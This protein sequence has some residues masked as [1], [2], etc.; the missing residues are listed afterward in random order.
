MFHELQKRLT[1]EG[2]VNEQK[3]ER[4]R[5]TAG[6]C[7]TERRRVGTISSS[8]CV[9][10]FLYLIR[11]SHAPKH[12]SLAACQFFCFQH[13]ILTLSSDKQCLPQNKL[14]DRLLCHLTLSAPIKYINGQ[15]M[16]IENVRR[17]SIVERI[18]SSFLIRR[19]LFLFGRKKTEIKPDSR[20][21]LCR[22]LIFASVFLS[23][24]FM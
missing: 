14:P 2:R 18:D 20:E 12:H 19:F 6:S 10:V 7:H 22:I 3:H 11:M 4:R 1:R 23:F 21:T 5:R 16:N 9:Y 24:L 8:P 15:R 13:P 17:G